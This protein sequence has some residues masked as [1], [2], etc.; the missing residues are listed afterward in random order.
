MHVDHSALLTWALF[1]S[2]DSYVIRWLNGAD[3]TYYPPQGYLSQPD[4]PPT[5]RGLSVGVNVTSD[6][7]CEC[8]T[9]TYNLY[10]AC[11]ACQGGKV[12][13]FVLIAFAFLC[14]R[15]LIRRRVL[16]LM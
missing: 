9:V 3:D 5:L 16:V 1:V 7:T 14:A 15:A 4:A 6:L 11:S 2:L 13:P 10:M 12:Y 8:D